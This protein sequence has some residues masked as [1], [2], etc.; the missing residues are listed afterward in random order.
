MDPINSKRPGQNIEVTI[1]IPTEMDIARVKHRNYDKSLTLKEV[2]LLYFPQIEYCQFF[3][4]CVLN[5]FSC[6][7]FLYI[8]LVIVFKS[9]FLD[10]LFQ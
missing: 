6:S 1:F 3:K 7:S 8:L 9:W 10:F 2:K 5:G 4:C